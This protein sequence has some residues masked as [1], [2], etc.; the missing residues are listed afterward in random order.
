MSVRVRFAPSPTGRMHVGNA[1]TAVIC[2]LFAQRH[3]GWFLLRIDDTDLERSKDELTELIKTDLSWLG[4]RWDDYVHQRD[5]MDRYHAVIEQLKTDGR[6]YACYETPEELELK[7]KVLLGRKLPPVYDRAA[8]A[9]TDDDRAKLEA[10]GR[11]PHWRFKLEHKPI[12]WHDLIRGEVKFDGALMS[13]PVLIR[14][15]GSPLYHLCS[16]IDDID[17]KITHV[18]R[19]EDHVSNTAAHVQ[20]FE[21]IGGHM[22]LFAHLPL[23]SDAEGGKLS[24]RLGSLSIGDLRDN[25]GLEPQAII[26][27]MGRLGTSEPIEPFADPMTMAA[28]FDFANFSRGTPKFDPEELIRLNAKIVH[29]LSFDAVQARLEAMTGA[30]VDEAF[31]E[32]VRPNLETVNEFKDWWAVAKGPV[33][34][35]IAPDDRDFVHQ[36]ATLLPAGEFSGETWGQWLGAIKGGTERK[37]KALFMPLRLA[38]TGMDHGPELDVLLPLIG[39][40]RALERLKAA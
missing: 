30:P 10:Q 13:D 8:L 12:V 31:W 23:I 20:M 21:A 3:K 24:K 1:R 38:L 16:V 34:G 33:T 2:W 18:V 40:A 5:R 39:R 15:D 25:T 28:T 22:P 7:R 11:K 35:S 37:G 32:A 9:L 17:Y 27:L 36:A 29:Q 19:G 6:L 26:S 14:E 4:I